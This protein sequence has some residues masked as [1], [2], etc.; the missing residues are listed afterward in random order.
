MHFQFLLGD[1]I[2]VADAQ[3]P[4]A[5][6]VDWTAIDPLAL[7]MYCYEGERVIGRM[8]CISIKVLEGTFVQ[9]DAPPTTAFRM[10]KQMCAMLNYLGDSSALA[11]VSDNTPQIGQYLKRVNFERFPVT[12]YSK[13]L[14]EKSEAA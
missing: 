7:V 11:M 4:K 1:E 12:L 9:P 2:A 14:A 5:Q 13:S 3:L 8:G 6:Q 10:M